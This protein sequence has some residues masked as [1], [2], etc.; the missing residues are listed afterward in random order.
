M[1]VA[2]KKDLE[3]LTTYELHQMVIK[4]QEELGQKRKSL[5]EARSRLMT[6]RKKINSLR[7]TVDYQRKRI[8]E[9]YQNQKIA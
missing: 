6:A 5:K 4:L 9:L 7:E 1:P 3:K 2:E 8:V